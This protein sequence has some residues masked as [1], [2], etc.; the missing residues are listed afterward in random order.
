MSERTTT[1]KRIIA[2]TINYHARGDPSA[3]AARVVAAVAEA[4]YE[5]VP[6]RSPVLDSVLRYSVFGRADA[7]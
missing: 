7:Q 1:I 4:G 3:L 2:N 6:R 5:I